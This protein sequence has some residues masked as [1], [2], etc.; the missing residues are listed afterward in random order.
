MASPPDT[1]TVQPSKPL[2]VNKFLFLFVGITLLPQKAGAQEIRKP[3]KGK[4][5]AFANSLSG[6]LVINM[7]SEQDAHTQENGYF[8]IA[9]K[10]GDTLMFS[11]T[12]FKAKKVPV[13]AAKIEE[14]MLLV[15][16]EPVMN[17]LDE[18]Q[19]FQYKGI[20]AVSLGIIPKST[21][22]YTPAERKLRTATGYDAQIGLNTSVTLDPVFNLLSGRT[23]ELLKNVVVEKKEILLAKIQARYEDE[24][25][26]KNMH[27]P[28]EH[29]KGFQFYL[30][31]NAR[32]ATAFNAKNYTMAAFIMSELSVQYLE[33]LAKEQD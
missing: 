15:R 1:F 7:Q 27:I 20:D 23:A 33:I 5:S 29:V 12:Q 25:F 21:K 17:H 2:T 10:P 9:V 32:F 26:T 30:A 11:S 6:I 16:L 8:D 3:L 31:E 13:T 28:Q 24:H 22:H 18:V 19:V 14:E 4:V